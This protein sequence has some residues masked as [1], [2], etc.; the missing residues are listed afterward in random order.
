MPSGSRRGSGGSHFGSSSRSSGGGSSSSLGGGS[1]WRGGMYVHVHTRGGFLSPF[2]AFGFF[3]LIIA[4]VM[5]SF[6]GN[7]DYLLEN[8]QF[9]ESDYAYYQKI[10]TD[11]KTDTDKQITAT[12][13]DVLYNEDIDGWYITYWFEMGG[14]T[15]GYNSYDEHYTFC[16]YKED[17]SIHEDPIG[18]GDPDNLYP[19]Q[20]GDPFPIAVNTTNA[21]ATV[22]SVNMDYEYTTLDNDIEYVQICNKINA[23]NTQIPVGIGALIIS[24]SIFIIGIVLAI[25]RSKK[26]KAEEIANSGKPTVETSATVFASERENQC[27]Y[28]GCIIKAGETT[29]KQCGAARKK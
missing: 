9:I 15:F 5:L 8:K 4:F 18:N 16:I 21:Y 3:F 26:Q 12:V 22:R 11:S 14:K 29:C 2:I 10:I 20:N 27:E 19:I 7:K 24:I 23:P 25:R 6:S 28:C 1:S 13:K 17:P